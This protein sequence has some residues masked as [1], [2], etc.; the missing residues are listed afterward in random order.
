MSIA[1]QS[2]SHQYYVLSYFRGILGSPNSLGHDAFIG[3]LL[4]LHGSLTEPRPILQKLNSAMAAVAIVVVFM[5][6][7]RSSFMA[8]LVGMLLLF[9]FYRSKFRNKIAIPILL[10]LL[11]L[12]ISPEESLAYIRNFIV[13]HTPADEG[14]SN[15]LVSRKPLWEAY[16]DGF[17]E[18]PWFGWGFGAMKGM[19]GSWNFELTSLGVMK[20]DGVNDVLFLLEGCGIVGLI[21]YLSLLYLVLSYRPTAKVTRFLVLFRK[22]PVEIGRQKYHHGHAIAYC[23]SVAMLCLFQLDDTA[24]SGG[25]FIPVLCWLHVAVAGVLKNGESL[26]Q[27]RLA[28]SA[29]ASG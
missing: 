4:Y 23:V 11:V 8:L 12:A 13:K 20:R 7:A 21:S 9:F 19:E 17:L 1:T 29:V 6:S 27:R 22:P 10:G 26:H 5:T 15:I 14:L 28:R 2:S 24:F 16:M 18:R 25:S 3:C